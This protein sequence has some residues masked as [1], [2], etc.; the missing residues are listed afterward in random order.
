MTA[1][2]LARATAWTSVTLCGALSLVWIVVCLSVLLAAYV[3]AAGV[4]FVL[5]AATVAGGRR[6]S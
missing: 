6:W 5:T 1:L 4:C 3:V 2:R